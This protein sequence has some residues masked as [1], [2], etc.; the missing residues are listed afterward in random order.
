VGGQQLTIID[1]LLYYS[2]GTF[3]GQGQ[4]AYQFSAKSEI[5]HGR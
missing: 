5:H 4:H 2:I 1:Q 3:M